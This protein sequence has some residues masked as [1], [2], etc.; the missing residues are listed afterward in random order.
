M[1]FCWKMEEER[2]FETAYVFKNQTV[3]KVQK[4]KIVSVRYIVIV[5][6]P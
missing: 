1:L 5:R 4:K 3:D 2:A 6:V